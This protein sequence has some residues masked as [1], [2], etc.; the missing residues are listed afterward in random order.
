M[1]EQPQTIVLFEKYCIYMLAGKR[2]SHGQ[3]NGYKIH[4]QLP[5]LFYAVKNKFFNAAIA[6]SEI[7]SWILN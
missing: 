3:N 6:F 1:F 2:K 5:R 4:E 7:P